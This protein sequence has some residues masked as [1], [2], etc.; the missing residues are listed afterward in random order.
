MEN[1]KSRDTYFAKTAILFC[2][3]FSLV[4]L[5]VFSY[6]YIRCCSNSVF[7]ASRDFVEGLEPDWLERFYETTYDRELGWRPRPNASGQ[8]K[9]SAG[10]SWHWATDKYGARRNQY[11]PASLAPYIATFG[12]SFTFGAEVDDNETWQN[13]LS[14]ILNADV[15]NYGVGGYGTDQAF[16]RFNKKIQQGLSPKIAVLSIYEENYKRIFN[17]FRP[18]LYAETGIK[19]GFKPRADVDRMGKLRF[20]GTPLKTPVYDRQ[21]L[22]EI[23]EASREGDFWAGFLPRFEFPFSFKLFRAAQIRLCLGNPSIPTCESA[24]PPTWNSPRVQ[25]IM[26]ALVSEFVSVCE[27]KNIVPVILFISRH[28][29]PPYAMFV[30]KLRE[31]VL[32]EDISVIDFSEAPSFDTSKVRIG[33]NDDAHFSPYGNKLLA[34]YIAQQLSAAKPN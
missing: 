32:T 6:V 34:E 13:F 12:D 2:I 4:L 1:M 30:D 16:L 22:L 26:G 11:F 14:N 19:L 20:L 33:P 23:V 10:Q 5:E 7:P 27:S 3:L 28:K 17:R 15:A 21:E 9:N 25:S 18:F 8:Q 24:T 31:E 29:N